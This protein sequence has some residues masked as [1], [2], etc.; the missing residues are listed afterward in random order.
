MAVATLTGCGVATASPNADDPVPAEPTM[1]DYV[2]PSL[3]TGL[4][5]RTLSTGDSGSRHVHAVYP[6]L[7]DAPRLTEKLRRT[8][9]GHLARFAPGRTPPEPGAEL[10]V[11]WQLAAVS[12][13]A[14][15]VR[16][17]VG[18]SAGADWRESR[19]TIWYDRVDRRAMDSADLLKD[20]AALE[21]LARR[22]RAELA[23][24]SS[25]VNPDVVRPDREMFDSIGF[26]P[27]GDLVVEFDDRQ[28]SPRTAGRLAVAVP[29]AEAR[30]LLSA[31]GER[32]RRAAV[33][34]TEPPAAASPQEALLAASAARPPARS[35]RAGS[36]DCAKLKCVAL[37]YDDGPGPET[38]RLLDILGRFGARAT[39]FSVGSNASAHP[40]LLVRM[41]D[42]GHLV[43]NH[44]WSHRDLTALSS[45]RISD[46]LTRAQQSITQS[47]GQVPTLMRPPYGSADG[48]VASLAARLGMSVVHWSVD[49]RDRRTSDPREIV[50]RVVGQTRPGAIVLMHD[51]YGATVDAAPEIL[52]RLGEEGYIFVTVPE[53]YGSREMQPGVT[54]DAGPGRPPGE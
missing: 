31:A 32:A 13:E 45:A 18:R 49:S 41:R 35:T 12:A 44:T 17:R 33:R 38:G 54:Y 3:V 43:A 14:V 28:V 24:R 9:T 23:G 52:R 16:L 6:S 36:V 15:G 42:E 48:H 11:D 53:L 21:M 27:R 8:V 39:F 50:E 34:T 5:T 4:S 10:N 40:E 46:Q 37:T 20:R 1:I 22:V 19:T 7:A 26:N 47:I 30:P 2:D 29:S 51:V 25:T